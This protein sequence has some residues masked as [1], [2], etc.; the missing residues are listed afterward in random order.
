MFSVLWQALIDRDARVAKAVAESDEHS[1]EVP[2]R[3]TA[4]RARPGLRPP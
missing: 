4:T 3:G 2:E 1:L